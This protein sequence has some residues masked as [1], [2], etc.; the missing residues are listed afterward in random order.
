VYAKHA[1]LKAGI[2]VL[3]A[4]AALLGL[5]FF[6]TGG[7]LWGDW[8]YYHLRVAAGDLA[9][10]AGDPV[11]VNGVDVGSVTEVELRTEEREAAALT[12]EERAALEAAGAKPPGRVRVTFVHAI[13]RVGASVLLPTDTLGEISERIT[14]TRV[15][16]LIP[17]GALERL[18]PEASSRQPIEVRQAPN[19]NTFAGRIATFVDKAGDAV[20]EIGD[21]A[22]SV[23]GFLAEAQELVKVARGKVD[24]LDVAAVNADVK[25][26]ATALRR[27]VTKLETRID[28]IAE[29]VAA[30]SADLKRMGEAG[31][32]V[33]AGL[34]R[35]LSVVLDNLKQVTT[36]L[37]GILERASP[38]VDVFLDDMDRV[39]KNLVSLSSEI[40][41]IGPEAR[42]L[43]RSVGSDAD[44]LLQALLDTGH[45][46]LDASEDIRAHP[47]KVL[48]EPSSDQIAFENLRNTMLNYVRA[49]QRM[50]E[51]AVTLRDLLSRG[52]AADPDVR[53][54]VQRTLAEFESS[55]DRYRQ[56]ERRLM[57][58]LQAGTPPSASAAPPPVPR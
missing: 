14:G 11:L 3:A 31:S 46:L 35:D 19:F 36:R 18:T 1:E 8:A 48:N 57:D 51:A 42:A 44:Q 5:L 7:T 17:G 28:E 40:Q 27:T 6:A 54:R 29:N 49:M 55:R 10:K 24:A 33:A 16:Q 38:K 2:V 21:I 12:P 30:A 53:A 47:W 15:L 32:R 26:T 50:N 23:R 41:G 39:G 9:P 34:E 52:S 56:M 58:L 20:T 22:D 25:E 4:S 43:I 45:N 37:D 13:A